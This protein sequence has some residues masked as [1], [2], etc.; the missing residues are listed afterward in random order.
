[1]RAGLKGNQ[2]PETEDEYN[3]LLIIG[4]LAF[5]QCCF[6]NHSHI[7]RTHTREGWAETQISGA[8]EDCF[9][10]LFNNEEDIL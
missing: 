3:E 7:G 10:E 2:L 4:G 6:G 9:D 5:K 1:M 8:C